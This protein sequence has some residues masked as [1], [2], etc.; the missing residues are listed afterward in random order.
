MNSLTMTQTD[1]TENLVRN[2]VSSGLNNKKEEN[3]E[4]ADSWMRKENKHKMFRYTQDPDYSH[5][6]QEIKIKNKTHTHTGQLRFGKAKSRNNK[7]FNP[8]TT[9]RPRDRSLVMWFS[10]NLFQIQVASNVIYLILERD[11]LYLYNYIRHYR[12]SGTTCSP[13][14]SIT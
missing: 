7:S 3:G 8:T 5:P 12:K 6:L 1:R 2:G 13:K 9:N 10:P 11:V 4:K 14:L